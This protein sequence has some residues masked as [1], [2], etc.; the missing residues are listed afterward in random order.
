MR[1]VRAEEGADE[2]APALSLSLS[3]SLTRRT[4]NPYYERHPWCK[5]IQVLSHLLCSTPCQPIWAGARNDFTRR[6]RD[7]SGPKHRQ[8]ARQVG[9]CC[10][11][12]NTFPLSSRWGVFSNLFSP[13]RCSVSGVSSSC[14]STIA[15]TRYFSPRG[16]TTTMV[17]DSLGGGELGGSISPQR[18]RSAP[19]VLA[20]LLAGGGGDE[21]TMA[22]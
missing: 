11:L 17:S 22:T 1:G 12:T 13:G 9:A 21:A 18:K 16:A 5:I 15:M 2:R 7:P 14:P 4:C 19:V 20:T 6:S 10:V 8:L 3:L